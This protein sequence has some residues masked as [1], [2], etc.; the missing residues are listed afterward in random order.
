[1]P[2]ATFWNLPEE[3]RQRIIDLAVAGF[4]AHDYAVA[5][6]SRIVAQAGISGYV[7]W[8]VGATNHARIAEQ[9]GYESEAAFNRAFKRNFGVPPA[10]WRK[11]AGGTVAEPTAA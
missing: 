7:D 5:S 9:V 10:A 4:A 11:G 6:L 1:M 2:K 8:V 3:K